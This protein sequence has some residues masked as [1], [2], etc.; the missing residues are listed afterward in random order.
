MNRRQIVCINQ[1]NLMNEKKQPL[2]VFWKKRMC[3]I[4]KVFLQISQNSQQKSVPDWSCRP[5]SGT[6]L[7]KRP[8]QEFSC[9]FCDI[10]KN[11]FFTEHLWTTASRYSSKYLFYRVSTWLHDQ[12]L[13]KM[14]VRKSIFCTVAGLQ[15]AT[16]IKTE[17]VHR[18][19]LI[20][21]ALM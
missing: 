4:K 17:H 21:S 10:L 2:K 11:I 14:P 16:L 3:S 20:C 6:L 15:P 13:Q 8:W 5:Q 9:E 12:N 18:H 7:K 1:W 19:N